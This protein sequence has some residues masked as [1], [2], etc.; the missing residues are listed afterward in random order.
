VRQRGAEAHL[1]VSRQCSSIPKH[2]I[3]SILFLALYSSVIYLEQRL[4]TSNFPIDGHIFVN[5]FNISV[6]QLTGD[7]VFLWLSAIGR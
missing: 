2:F 6:K 7:I 4:I 1:Q 5:Y 3:P